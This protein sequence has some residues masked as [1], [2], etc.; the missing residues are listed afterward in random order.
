MPMLDTATYATAGG[1]TDVG[2]SP[3][4]WLTWALDWR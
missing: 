2:R 4:V 3:E 1:A